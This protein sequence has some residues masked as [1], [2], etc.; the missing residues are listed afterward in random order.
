MQILALEELSTKSADPEVPEADPSATGAD[1]G[2]LAWIDQS[3]I[4]LLGRHLIILIVVLIELSPVVDI[5]LELETFCALISHVMEWQ[6]IPAN[7]CILD[8][9]RRT[10]TVICD[11]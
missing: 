1:I 9:D 8:S 7:C 4:D 2:R 6:Q 3:L 10:S 5:E 11:M